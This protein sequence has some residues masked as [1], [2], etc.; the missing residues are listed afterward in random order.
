LGQCRDLGQG[1]V[2]LLHGG[3][4]GGQGF[5]MDVDGGDG[6]G[7]GEFEQGRGGGLPA[8]CRFVGDFG[9]DSVWNLLNQFAPY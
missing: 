4:S 5:D 2:G 1:T 8:A 7:V 6:I 9:D 3:S